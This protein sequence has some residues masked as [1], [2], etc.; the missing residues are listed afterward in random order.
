MIVFVFC[1]EAIYGS[2]HRKGEVKQSMVSCWAVKWKFYLDATEEKTANVEI[3]AMEN[4]QNAT[5]RE[6]KNENILSLSNLL[7][8]YQGV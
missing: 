8:D 3:M 7:D 1:L 5:Y 2:W 6:N 4:I